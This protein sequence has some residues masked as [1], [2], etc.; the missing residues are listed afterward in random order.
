MDVSG[1]G[2]SSSATTAASRTTGNASAAFTLGGHY[3]HP[4]AQGEQYTK[5]NGADVQQGF[6][7]RTKAGTRTLDRQGFPGVTFRGEYPIGKVTYAEKGFPVEVKLEAF[8]PFIPL[9]AKDSALPATVMSYTVTN[10]SDAPVDVDLGSWMQ[11]ATC[12]YTTDARPRA[13]QEPARSSR[14]PG[15][16]A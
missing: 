4:V 16:Y 9:N 13:A 5:W 8:S 15:Q 7:V 10:T 6:L 1:S 2:I 11:N 12:P 14:R 3:A